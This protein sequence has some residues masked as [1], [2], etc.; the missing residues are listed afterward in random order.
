MP[1]PDE[2]AASAASLDDVAT[3]AAAPIPR[4]GDWAATVPLDL[5]ERN[6]FWSKDL[7]VGRHQEVTRL[8][9]LLREGRS[10]LLIGGRRVGKSTLTRQLSASRIQRTLVRADPSGW[11][12]SSMEAGLGA[13]RGELEGLL[14]TTY[15][16]ATRHE[17]VTML[18]Q[19]S[20]VALVIDEADYLLLA[21]WG[22]L[23]YRFLRWLDD[24]HLRESISI[25]LAGGPVLA[26]YRDKDDGGSPPLNTTDYNY[27]RPLD[28]NAVMELASLANLASECDEIFA[29]C[30]GQAWLTTILLAERWE[31][32]PFE[33]ASDA[34][35]DKTVAMYKVWEQ[36][37]GDQGRELLRRIPSGGVPWTAFNS[38]GSWAK[39]RE[40]RTFSQ[41]VGA[42]RR[43]GD[44]VCHGPRIFADWFADGGSGELT[45]DIA[46]SY[47]GEDLALA[48]E[49]YAQLQTEFRVFFAPAEAAAL[50]GTDLN[51]VLPN[52][53]GV[54][55]KYVLVLSTEHYVTKHWTRLEFDAVAAKAPGR[56]L[57]L[58]LG[59]R[60][61]DLPAGMVYRGSTPAEMVGLMAA[62]RA[63][64]AD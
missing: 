22:P 30:G 18:E 6:P 32:V 47:A 38:R 48:R 1:T 27:V 33:D 15:A 28:R 4:P 45:W 3:E 14:P 9:K 25:L 44:R 62:V 49:I 17:I 54:H 40:A 59:A 39:Y 34:L 19:A 57:L 26:L 37:L 24:T 36:Q 56:I 64:M 46:I 55:S 61:E 2:I 58:D 16:E 51:D 7:F 60:P 21:P 11:N 63:K 42:I 20:P 10:A 52:T 31:G 23:F 5:N 12:L 13:L 41:S 43:D 50:W 29:L 8:E 53:Y 35:F